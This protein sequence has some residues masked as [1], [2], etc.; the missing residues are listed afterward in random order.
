MHEGGVNYCVKV[1]GADLNSGRGRDLL[2]RSVMWVGVV[3]SCSACANGARVALG[4][5]ISNVDRVLI[6]G[7]S[8]D[9][10]GG[11]NWKSATITRVFVSCGCG[12]WV[13]LGKS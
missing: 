2:A 12:A 8:L 4:E 11:S 6:S 9:E 7:S 5:R 1:S 10:W 13:A 3:V